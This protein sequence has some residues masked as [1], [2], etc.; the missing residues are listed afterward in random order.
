MSC[1]KVKGGWRIKLE[2][3]KIFPKLYKTKAMCQ[4]RVDQLQRHS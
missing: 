2:T 1:I 4:V 3:G